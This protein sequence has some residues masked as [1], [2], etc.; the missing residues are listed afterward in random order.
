MPV[1]SLAQRDAFG[2]HQSYLD[3]VKPL[4]YKK[5]VDQIKNKIDILKAKLQAETERADSIQ[6][7]TQKYLAEEAALRLELS[8][9]KETLDRE[10]NEYKVKMDVMQTLVE[11]LSYKYK[12]DVM[13]L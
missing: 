12:N 8:Q 4:N 5:E 9:V 7:A 3:L 1:D 11:G 2:F 10:Q 6:A 13:I